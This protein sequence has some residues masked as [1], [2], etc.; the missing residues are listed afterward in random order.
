MINLQDKVGKYELVGELS[1]GGMGI[2]YQ[3]YDPFMDRFVALKLPKFHK[4]PS[5][6]GNFQRL[7]Y[8][9][10]HAASMLHHPNIIEVYDAGIADEMHY[11][12]MEYVSGGVTLKRF[13]HPDNLLPLELAVQMVVKAAE[14]LDFAHRKGILHRDIKP[15]NILLKDDREV[16]LSDF[17]LSI[18]L[19]P[20]M[21]DTQS[22]SLMGSPL[23]MAP[24]RLKEEALTQHSDIYSLG[25]V[26]YELLTGRPPFLAD[27]L[28]ALAQQIM[29]K[30][31]VAPSTYRPN[32]P[33]KIDEI[34]MKAISKAPV[35]RYHSMLDFGAEISEC[36][37][38]MNAP[39]DDGATELR[40]EQLRSLS[41]FNEFT[42]TDLWELLRWSTWQEVIDGDVIIREGDIDQSV[43]LIVNGH[44]E[45]M[46]REKAIAELTRGEII[47]EIAF[48]AERKRT[49]TVKAKGAGSLLRITSNQ[50]EQASNTCQI[51]FHRK[52][53]ATLINRLVS[54]T[55][56]LAKMYEE[57]ASS[58]LFAGSD[59]NLG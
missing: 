44:F 48:L 29:N 20:D 49:A 34:V 53:I 9:E 59:D 41:F 58:S 14:A 54:T 28:G 8:N 6:N 16:K 43:Y 19:D 10:T 46:K 57:E 23:Y 52:F 24:E 12:A 7:F 55:E 17:G 22:T 25:V 1:G 13:C 18:L 36:C 4:D 15:S 42:D 40:T 3:A 33:A 32:L 35:E 39:M 2:V 21:V 45:V 11:I 51:Q 38:A 56:Q 26:M 5:A 27:S 47:G 37:D 30:Q 31:P 50:I